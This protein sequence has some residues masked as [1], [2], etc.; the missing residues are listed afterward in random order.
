MPTLFRLTGLTEASIDNEK[1]DINFVLKVSDGRG[2]AFVAEAAAARQ[3][4]SSLGRMALQAQQSA[5]QMI[6][7][8]K[9]GGYGVK[10]DAFGEVVLLQLISD[11]GVPHMF[12]I[13][14]S[15]A[16]DI[17]C[18]AANGIR[19]KSRNGPRLSLAI[20]AV[21]LGSLQAAFCN[22][23]ASR[24]SAFLGSHYVAING[25]RMKRGVT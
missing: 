5:P 13:P 8:E 3:I 24:E 12:A 25:R 22:P 15:A 11:D 21:Q 23:H 1:N 9:V 6:G 14:L 2:L 17:A 4:A 20:T 18:S 10:R 7:A 19:K 16:T